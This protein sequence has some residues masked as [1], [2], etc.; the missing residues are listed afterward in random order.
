MKTM[1]LLVA[2]VAVLVAV[3][4]QAQLKPEFQLKST[5]KGGSGGLLTVVNPEVPMS[6]TFAGKN[7]DFDRV[8][9][10]EKLDRELT[11][12][13]YGQ[14]NMLMCFK[15]ANRYFGP[16]E[17]IL[18]EQG[19][20]TDFLYLACTES[21]MDPNAYSTA[22]AAGIWQLLAET[23]RQYG[24]EVND[25]VDERYD[26]ERSTV[27]AC[28]YLKAAY[29]KYGD[30]PT[31]AASY[32]AGMGRISSELSKQGQS[33]S[34]NLW[35]NQETTRY[36]YRILSYKLIMENPQKYGYRLK[37]KD[38]YQPMRY[39]EEE[40]MTSVESWVGWAKQRGLTYAQLREANP[41]IRS[42]KLT[43]TSGKTYRVRVPKSDDMYR[44][45]RRVVV[46]NPKWVVD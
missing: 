4:A 34:F 13:I 46:Y 35:I 28:K 36:V 7:I 31:A 29:A 27:A 17:R 30:W 45:K 26:P 22:K 9:M 2:M 41:W 6:V 10:A 21:T 33:S 42:T 8:D 16:M 20:P 40:V 14:T 32:N 25:E 43:N 23:G 37:R 12:I 39:T 19:V 44:S 5:D 38:L 18:R 11:S 3:A 15:R 1:R 24:L